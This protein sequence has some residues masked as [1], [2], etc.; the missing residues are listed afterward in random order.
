MQWAD[1]STHALFYVFS[2]SICVPGVS[3]DPQSIRKYHPLCVSPAPSFSKCVCQHANLQEVP[4]L[5]SKGDRVTIGPP[6]QPPSSP[7]LMAPP[8]EDIESS[9]PE[10]AG[11]GLWEWGVGSS[12]S[13]V[14]K[15]T[16][17]ETACPDIG[18][19]QRV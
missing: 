12:S 18:T 16:D 10:A 17:T 5:R 2:P 15:A 7:E 8:T 6:P 4:F 3:R 14:F 19:K 11:H 1:F 13:F 9:G